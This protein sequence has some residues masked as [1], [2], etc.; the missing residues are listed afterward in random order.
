MIER[1]TAVIGG[2]CIAG[3]V[4]A[5]PDAGYRTHADLSAWVD[6][7]DAEHGRACVV[8]TIGTSGEGR[9]LWALRAALPGDVEPDER[10]AM[11]IVAN[12]D[13]AHLVGSEVAMGVLER[14]L[15]AAGGDEAEAAHAELAGRFL[16]EYTLYVVPR[17]NP[18][19]AERFF[20]TVRDERRRNLRP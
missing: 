5:A 15:A 13:G 10:P 3:A 14:L 2:L 20:S 7:L 16:T 9:A 17:V 19:A 11:L 1:M 12:V 8:E 6:R 18:D 4:S